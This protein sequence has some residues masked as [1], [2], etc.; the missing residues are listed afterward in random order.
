MRSVLDELA[1]EIT[2]LGDWLRLRA[3]PLWLAHGIDH[4]AGMFHEWIEAGGPCRANYRRVRVAARQVVTF[5]EAA[6]AGIAGASG[7]SATVS[8]A[9]TLRTML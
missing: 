3:W 7:A 1:L 4:R 5:S 6:R 2:G 9:L 8:P